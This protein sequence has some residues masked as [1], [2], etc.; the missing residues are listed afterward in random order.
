M[1]IRDSDYLI[2]CCEGLAAKP[3]VHQ[4]IVGDAELD[5]VF[6][7]CVEHRVRNL[8]ADLVRM[9]FRN[10]LARKKKIRVSHRCN[11]SRGAAALPP[12]AMSGWF[13]QRRRCRSRCGQGWA[14]ASK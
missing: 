3:R 2:G 10:R 11:S 6:Q 1:C 7:K 5:V 14:D 8:I 9:T 12:H 4:A 13:L